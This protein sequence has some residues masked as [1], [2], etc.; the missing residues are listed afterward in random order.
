MKNN[1]SFVY[2]FCLVVLDFLALIIGFV[3]AYILRVKIDDRSLIGFVSARSFF[4]SLLILAIFWIIIF[5]FLGLY[6]NSIYEKRFSEFGRLL[7]GS[8][9]GLLFILS[10]AY[11]SKETIFP[12][13]LVPAYG[14]IISVSLL[15]IFRNFARL[16]RGRL[17]RYGIGVNNLLL[18]GNSPIVS[19]LVELFNNKDS[20]YKIVGVVGYNGD[21]PKKI[22]K[23]DNFAS[24]IDKL[25]VDDINAILQAE[26]F[27][28]ANK[29]NDVLEYA[30]HHHISYRFIPGNSELFVGNIDVE[31]FRSSIPVVAVG[32]TALA[33]WGR[34]AKRL[35]DLAITLP[36]VIIL[37][38][39]YLLIALLIFLSD[40]GMPLFSQKRTTR[41]NRQFSI[42]KFRTMKNKYNGLSPEEAF[43][44]MGRPTL[45]TQY[46][47]NGDQLPNDPR[48]SKLGRFLRVTSLDELPQLWNV[49]KGDISLVGPRALVPEEI[50]Q[51]KNNHHI[52]SVKSGVTGL[53][54]VSGR[55]DISF[56]ER[57]KLDVYYVQNWSFWLDLII[58]AKTFRIIINGR[59]AK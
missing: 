5:A 26:L 35:F 45:A 59:G 19:E 23:F 37:S 1:A 57:R 4:A 48:I 11:V 16:I 12:A 44:K 25:S 51:A 27:S 18:V 47:Q 6:N 36:L 22:K 34:I 43:A 9:V 32:Q 29:N 40:F 31:L 15:I 38:P 7:V 58:L 14:F 2:S 54:Q 49:I 42:Y 30:Q 55:K 33:G 52:L 8:F 39:L 21:L 56:E 17:F 20:G 41:Y 3:G 50:R 10:V 13:R 46:R 28:N 53:A 24:A